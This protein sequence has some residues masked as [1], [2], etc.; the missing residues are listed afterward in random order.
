MMRVGM[1]GIDLQD[2]LV[3]LPGGVQAAS[4]LVGEGDFQDTVYVIHG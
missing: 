1:T 3:N 2:L 4:L